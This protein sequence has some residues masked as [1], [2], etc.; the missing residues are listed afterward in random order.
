MLGCVLWRFVEFEG[1]AE[2]AGEVCVYGAGGAE[3]A[4]ERAIGG[5]DEEGEAESIGIGGGA[6]GTL[7]ADGSVDEEVGEFG[8]V[9]VGELS[10][11]EEFDLDIAVVDGECSEVD[12]LVLAVGIELC[13]AVEERF[14]E[15]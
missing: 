9:G 15:A 2:E 1:A 8:G 3:A 13:D 4:G 7:A 14:L 11:V 12:E 6:G 5:A 10:V